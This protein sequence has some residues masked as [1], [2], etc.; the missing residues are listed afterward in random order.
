MSQRN[1]NNDKKHQYFFNCV[2]VP[3]NKDELMTYFVFRGYDDCLVDEIS[4]HRV[5]HL[6][7]HSDLSQRDDQ[8]HQIQH[9][10]KCSY[11]HWINILREKNQKQRKRKNNSW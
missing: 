7:S 10:Y 9:L 5:V 11:K 8:C 2:Q 6:L 3:K 4:R 1:Q